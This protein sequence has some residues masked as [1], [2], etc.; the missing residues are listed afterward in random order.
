MEGSDRVAAVHSEDTEGRGL[1]SRRAA[2]KTTL[3]T[4]TD[5]NLNNL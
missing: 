5:Q 2:V 4:H 3:L 1:L